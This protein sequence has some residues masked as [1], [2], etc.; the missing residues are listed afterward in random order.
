MYLMSQ[1]DDQH[2]VPIWTI[3]NFN[4][5]KKLTSDI[6]LIIEV[7]RGMS[8]VCHVGNTTQTGR[9]S[10]LFFLLPD[11]LKTLSKPNHGQEPQ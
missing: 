4:A 1:M 10:F 7:L 2:Y 3:A 6:D 9:Y 11:P 5:V 8:L